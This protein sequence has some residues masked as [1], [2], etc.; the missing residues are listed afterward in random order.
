MKYIKASLA[1]LVADLL[2]VT[3]AARRIKVVTVTSQNNHNWQGSH[4]ALEGI[5]A[6]S[7]MFKVDAAVSSAKERCSARN[8]GSPVQRR[9][10]WSSAVRSGSAQRC[11]QYRC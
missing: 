4:V 7:G 9:N 11:G 3:C 10:W 5:L 2:S 8:C 6:N 1:A